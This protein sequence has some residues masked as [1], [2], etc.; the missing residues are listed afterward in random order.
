MSTETSLRRP[1]PL[2]SRDDVKASTGR[3][4]P[5][6]NAQ[7]GRAILRSIGGVNAR[8]TPT[9]GGKQAAPRAGQPLAQPTPSPQHPSTKCQC[10]APSPPP[11]R[12]AREAPRA[13]RTAPRARGRRACAPTTSGSSPCLVWATPNRSRLYKMLYRRPRPTLVCLH[14]HHQS[15][16]GASDGVPTRRLDKGARRRLPLDAVRPRPSACL[17]R[18][19]QHYRTRVRARRKSTPSR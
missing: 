15:R 16:R 1:R 12:E 11:R 9:P 17:L 7:Q 18:S 13:T 6:C 19:S 5:G 14:I 10:S 4:A 8:P 2:R 3:G